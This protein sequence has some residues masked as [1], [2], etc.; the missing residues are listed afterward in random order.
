MGEDSAPGVPWGDGLGK[1][2]LGRRRGRLV[3]VQP[4]SAAALE[5]R[6]LCSSVTRTLSVNVSSFGVLA[7]VLASGLRALRPFAAGMRD[8]IEGAASVGSVLFDHPQSRFKRAFKTYPN[9]DPPVGQSRQVRALDFYSPAHWPSF[10]P[11]T[12]LGLPNPRDGAG[13]FAWQL[14]FL[15]IVYLNGNYSAGYIWHK[16]SS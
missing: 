5:S 16:R 6:F 14:R 4:R 2:D 9:P 8:T 12:A 15:P 1:G 10:F 7:T 3:G 11:W 13:V